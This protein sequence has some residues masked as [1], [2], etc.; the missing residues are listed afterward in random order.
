[1]Y[2]CV[3]TEIASAADPLVCMYVCMYVCV[4]E[5]R[6]SVSCRPT[7]GHVCVCVCVCVNTEIASAADEFQ[8]SLL[9]ADAD[10]SYDS[11]VEI[12]LDTVCLCSTSFT[13]CP[14]SVLSGPVTLSQIS[15]Y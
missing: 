15:W 9:M 2:V 11:V 14:D 6:D 12:N 7:S 8:K 5:Y 13:V 4:C 3:N 10:C 1:M